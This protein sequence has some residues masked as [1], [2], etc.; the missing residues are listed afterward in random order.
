MVALY[1]LAAV[2][3]GWTIGVLQAFF[4]FIAGDLVFYQDEDGTY[5]VIEAEKPMKDVQKRSWV[6]FRVRQDNTLLNGTVEGD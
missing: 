5:P 3:V 1:I 2:F 4:T 6:L